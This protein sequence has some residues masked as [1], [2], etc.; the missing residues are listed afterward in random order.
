M[1]SGSAGLFHNKLGVD[2]KGSVDPEHSDRVSNR[3]SF[4]TM[5]DLEATH[6]TGQLISESKHRHRSPKIAIKRGGDG[7]PPRPLGQLLLYPI[8]CAEEGQ[9]TETCHQ[10]QNAFVQTPHFKMEEIHTLKS[11][12]RQG[13]WLVKIDLKDAY[14]SIPIHPDHMSFSVGKK[15]YHFTCLPFGLASAPQSL[16][17]DL[18]TG[19]SSRTGAGN[20]DDYI[21]RRYFPT[22]NL[23]RESSGSRVRP[24]LPSRV[25]TINSEKTILESTQSLEFLGFTVNTMEM[26]LSLPPQK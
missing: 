9:G 16:Y 26:E 7:G 6:P 13:D 3:I 20:A 10:S 8:P 23:Q 24:S 15:S 18:E 2:N 1:P 25:S 17:Q 21:H 5:S 11:L 14:F 19:S 4:N 22:G 12:L